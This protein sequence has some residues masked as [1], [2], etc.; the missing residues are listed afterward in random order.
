MTD[1]D[2][3]TQRIVSC[4]GEYGGFGEHRG[5]GEDVISALARRWGASAARVEITAPLQVHTYDRL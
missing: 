1:G 4:S 3:V 2:E 5:Y